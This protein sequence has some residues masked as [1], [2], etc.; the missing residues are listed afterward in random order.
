MCQKDGNFTD[1]PN[2]FRKSAITDHKQSKVHR[3][4]AAAI[5]SKELA[6]AKPETTAAGQALLQL[7][8]KERSCLQ[9]LFKTANALAKKIRPMSD[10]VWMAELEASLGVDVGTTYINPQM[11]GIFKDN[12]AKVQSKE[13]L[14]NIK[15]S[16]YSL[17][18]DGSNDI[19]SK[20]Q[21]TIFAQKGVVKTAFLR[22]SEPKSELKQKQQNFM[23]WSVR[24]LNRQALQLTW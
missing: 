24:S 17:S 6:D 15:E 14:E 3:K 12:I 9:V 23:T 5:A 4:T 20:E 13:Q 18:M 1:G 19:N 16:F 10:M 8:Q 2:N 21:E 11:C 7:K 22:I